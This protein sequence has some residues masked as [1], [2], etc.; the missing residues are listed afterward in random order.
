VE[1]IIRTYNPKAFYTIEE[2]KF[3]SQG[4]FPIQAAK[5]W[6]KGK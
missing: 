2:V 1:D 5:R 4:V 3:V 6:R